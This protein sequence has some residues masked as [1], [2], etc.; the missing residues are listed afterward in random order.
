MFAR[1]VLQSN[2]ISRQHKGFS[3]SALLLI[4]PANIDHFTTSVVILSHRRGR[5]K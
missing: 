2:L 3:F 4:S 1:A 5:A